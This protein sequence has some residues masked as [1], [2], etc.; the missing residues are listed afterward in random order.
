MQKLEQTVAP[1]SGTSLAELAA[2]LA[3]TQAHLTEHFRYEEQNGY[4]DTV[5]KREP[6]LERSIQQL[7]EEHRQL[8]QSLQALRAKI[9]SASSLDEALRTR[10]RAWVQGV[11]DHEAKENELVEAAFNLDISAED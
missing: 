10:V 6:R 2:H 11:R 5:R 8:R 4:L 9:E 3:A 1:R 7:G